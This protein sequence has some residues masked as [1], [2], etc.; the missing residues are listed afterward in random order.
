MSLAPP[1]VADLAA[2]TGRDSNTFTNYAPTALDQATL[3]FY[4]ATELSEY[5][6]DTE[7]AKLVKYG[8]MDMADKIYLSQKYAEAAASP[9]QSESIGSYSYSKMTQAVKKKLGTGVMWFDLAVSKLKAPGSLIGQTGSI[10]GM[11]WDGLERGTD[12]R[13][14]IIGASGSHS[15]SRNAWDMDNVEEVIHYHSIV[16]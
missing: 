12:G 14:R 11:E 16:D 3:L 1:T 7:L 10:E 13:S 5:P 15:T 8:I 4:F 6:D 2:F 9:F